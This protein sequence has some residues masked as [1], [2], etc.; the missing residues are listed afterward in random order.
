MTSYLRNLTQ[1]VSSMS[2]L[3]AILF[4]LFIGV[5]FV[6]IRRIYA[7]FRHHQKTPSAPARYQNI[8]FVLAMAS[9]VALCLCFPFPIVQPDDKFDWIAACAVLYGTCWVSMGAVMSRDEEC[10]MLA[11]IDTQRGAT[12]NRI[13]VAAVK[14]LVDASRFC[15]NGLLF[16]ALG[17]VVQMGH[18][19]Y[20]AHPNYFFSVDS[21]PSR[22]STAPAAG[23][24]FVSPP[25][26]TGARQS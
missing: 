13:E 16:V 23:D 15:R 1:T 8:A 21:T 26:S 22:V 10:S 7:R 9:M 6:A 20:R 24:P 14:A 17:S 12:P 11:L 5:S 25:K 18:L 19:V 2:V 4:W 3:Q